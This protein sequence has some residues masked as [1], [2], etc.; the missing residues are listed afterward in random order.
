[1][2]LFGLPHV[3]RSRGHGATDEGTTR[4]DTMQARCNGLVVALPA[5]FSTPL[6][7]RV[8]VVSGDY[9]EPRVYALAPTSL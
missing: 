8:R 9:G 7:G 1:M 6:I 4:G 2:E 3:E 5:A